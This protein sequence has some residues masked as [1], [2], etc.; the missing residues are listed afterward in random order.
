MGK[1]MKAPKNVNESVASGQNMIY[2]ISL[3]IKSSTS[4]WRIL[5]QPLSAYKLWQ[6]RPI[7]ASANLL[8]LWLVLWFVIK[9]I[10][11]GPK[12]QAA[13]THNEPES[14]PIINFPAKL[15]TICSAKGKEVIL[16]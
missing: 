6:R 16:W 10:C 1:G 12:T 8:E 3:I 13:V 9:L 14:V 4:F 11:G 2:Y 15:L 7:G 5:S